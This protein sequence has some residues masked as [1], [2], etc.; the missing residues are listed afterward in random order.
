[1]IVSLSA[2]LA[3]KYGLPPIA[4]RQGSDPA[5]AALFDQMRATVKRS[6]SGL[7]EK[8]SIPAHMSAF[9]LPMTRPQPRFCSSRSE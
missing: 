6:S 5:F 8:R 4:G 9:S 3:L 2:A 7:T 1:L